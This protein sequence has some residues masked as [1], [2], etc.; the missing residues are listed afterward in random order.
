M[1]FRNIFI[2]KD[3]KI[4]IKNEQLIIDDKIQKV[5]VPLEDINSICIESLQTNVT[6]YTLAKF[7]EHDIILYIC[8]EKH[9]PTGVLLGINNYSRQLRNLKRQL[10][11]PKPVIKRIWQDII[12]MKINNQANV[13][14]EINLQDLEVRNLIKAVQSGDSTNVEAR[15]AALYFKIIFGKDFSR[16]NE[17][18]CNAALNYG[19]SII[20]GMIA[21]TLVSYGFETSLGIFHCNQLNNFN[22]VDDI[23]EVFRPVVDLF[24]LTNVIQTEDELTPQNKR[25][26]FN[27]VNC[28]VLIEGKYYNMQ[29][30]IDIVVKSLATSFEKKENAIKLPILDGV[31]LYRYA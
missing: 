10:E 31:K 21:R 14:K 26:I 4:N 27:V 19:Y 24:I 2:Q 11:M 15:A 12:K 22:L 17:E 30:A 6:T 29:T 25:E 1:A 28:L 3:L 7:I 13:V 16:R 5:T 23:I 20:R 9:L 18:F 8:N